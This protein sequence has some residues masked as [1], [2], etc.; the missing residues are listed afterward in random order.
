MNK[1]LWLSIVPL[2]FFGVYALGYLLPWNGLGHHFAD[3]QR[4]GMLH[5]QGMMIHNQINGG[6][7]A[8]CLEQ[9]CSYCFKKEGECDCL[10]EVLN[11][12]HPCGECMGEILE[13][14]GNKFLAKYFASALADELG[15]DHK[16]SLQQIIFEKYQ[17]PI[18]EQI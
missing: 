5:Q 11:G 3:Y 18:E 16:N 9:P 15:N 4:T 8:C 6:N 10:E 13:G 2:L 17:I 1:Y 12:E 14:K 7:Y